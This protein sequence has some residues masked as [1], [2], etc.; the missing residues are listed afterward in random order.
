MVASVSGI[1]PRFLDPLVLEEVDARRWRLVHELRYNSALLG[2]TVI[3]PAGRVTDLSSV[4]RLPFAYWL[5]GDTGRKAG[6][7]H[8][9]VYHWHFGGCPRQVADAVFREALI[10][11]GVPAWRAALMY[12][13]VRLGGATAWDA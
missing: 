13:G 11:E 12:V 5:A 10:A 4:P 3:V 1:T 9:E 8:D 7:I 2:A 6:V